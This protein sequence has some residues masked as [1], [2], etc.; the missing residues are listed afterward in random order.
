VA[1]F[2]DDMIMK[3]CLT[4][5]GAISFLQFDTCVNTSPTPTASPSSRP[6]KSLSSSPT[7]RAKVPPTASPSSSPVVSP[8]SAPTSVP[9]SDPTW[10]QSDSPSDAPSDG[11][12]DYPS[13]MPSESPSTITASSDGPSDSPS[14]APSDEPSSVTPRPTSFLSDAPSDTPSDQPSDSPSDVPSDAPSEEPTSLSFNSTSLPTSRPTGSPSLQITASPT[15][16]PIVN[17]YVCDFETLLPAVELADPL[18]AQR[19]LEA[20]AV[21]VKATNTVKNNPVNVFNSSYIRGRRS[22]FDPDLGSPN[23]ACPGGGP[24]IGDGGKPN[25]IFRTYIL[26]VNRVPSL[27]KNHSHILYCFHYSQL[28][29]TWQRTDYSKRAET[30]PESQ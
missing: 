25:S 19:L 18:Q 2:D 24:G 30:C 13:D 22:R 17:T 12:S 16:C 28:R 5:S 29:A 23:E 7:V 8:S 20:C 9:T 6:T 26:L 27:P 1:A 4:G 11:P 21:T 3:V 10:T 15:T 14:D